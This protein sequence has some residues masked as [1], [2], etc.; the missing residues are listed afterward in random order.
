[1]TIS[2]LCLD[3]YPRHRLQHRYRTSESPLTNGRANT[4]VI[5]KIETSVVARSW[6][7][8]STMTNGRL[9]AFERSVAGR[10]FLKI[11]RDRQ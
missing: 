9:C 11:R 8:P 1:M 6:I 3:S 10:D 2:A 7:S 4:Q 5:D